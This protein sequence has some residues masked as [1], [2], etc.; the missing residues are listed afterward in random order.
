[1]MS[2]ETPR[3]TLDP[4]AGGD[5]AHRE[6]AGAGWLGFAAVLLSIVGCLNIIGGIAAIDGANVYTAHANYVISS[7]NTWGWVMTATGVAQILAAFGVWAR[8]Q[9][10]RWV[11]V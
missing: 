1:M 8:N 2:V 10:A 7:L 9:L 6:P 5:V 3:G 4:K 11:G